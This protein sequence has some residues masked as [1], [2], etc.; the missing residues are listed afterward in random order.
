MFLF[1]G[2]T[3]NGDLKTILKPIKKISVIINKKV[4]ELH[5]DNEELEYMNDYIK[6][7][8]DIIMNGSF[9]NTYKMSWAKALVELSSSAN[10]YDDAEI[11]FTFEQIAD[12]YFK[13]YWNQTIYFDLK[14]GSNLSK[15]PEVLRN[16][17]ALIKMYFEAKN[18]FL[19]D[20]IEKIDFA[21]Y[22]LEEER[23]IVRKKI[24]S[25]LK[26]DVCYRFKIV[27]DNAYDIYTL[28]KKQGTITFKASQ[29]KTL[30]AY[31]DLLLQVI[32]YRWTQML[33]SFNHSP[34]ISMKVRAIDEGKI[35]RNSLKIFHKYLNLEV[36]EG[37]SVCFYC[38]QPLGNDVS[39]D[40]VIPWSFMFSDDLWNLVYCHQGENSSKS[41]CRPSED[42]I[43]RLE[44]RNLNLLAR[45]EESSLRRDKKYD[46]L[47]LAIE[48][49]YVRKFWMS[50]R[51]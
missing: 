21:L 49:D 39:V 25:T 5:S 20:R 18:S 38:G 12:C 51:G 48:R 8:N 46:E 31:T 45:F 3:Y 41:N 33:E 34:R 6:A 4:K 10:I 40:H 29:V 37:K 19:P 43:S 11:T 1:R 7:W 50:F 17:K 22:G 32:N 27:G 13:Y 36:Y 2:I 14:Q 42:I 16:V 23:E 28:D 9:D 26:K 15:L 44:L 30:R 24:I 47:K 35:R